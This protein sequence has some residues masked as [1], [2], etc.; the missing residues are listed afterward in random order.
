MRRQTGLAGHP[1]TPLTAQL[2]AC[3]GVLA[4]AFVLRMVALDGLALRGDEA[5]AV[6]GWT[7]PLAD[8]LGETAAVE[9]QPPLTFAVF[10]GWVTFAGDSE[11]A[12]RYLSV[13]S[14]VAGVAAVYAIGRRV[15]GVWGGALAALLMALNPFHVWHSQDARSYALWTALSALAVW[16]MLRA[17]ARGDRRDWAAYVVA[18][19]A[20]A[21]TFYLELAL[22]AFQNVYVLVTRR[23]D[24]ARLRRWF[25][26]QGMV[27]LILALWY[28]QPRLWANDYVGTAGGF[29]PAG[30]LTWVVPSLVFGQTLPPG[31]ADWVWVV[32][33]ALV[34]AG[35]VVAWR[36]DRAR[37]VF[38]AS[39][40]GAPL[41]LL[42]ALALVQ[43]IF[44]PRYILASSPA[45]MLMLAGLV[46]ALA[47]WRG[48]SA[49]RRAYLVGGL[50]SGLLLVMGLGLWHHY[51]NPMYRKS[52][53]WRGL[54]AFLEARVAPGDI[55]A[56]NTSDPAFGYYYHGAQTTV[57]T[58]PHPDPADT[59]AQLEALLSVHRAL[60]FLPTINPAWDADATALHWLEANAQLIDDLWSG[61]FRVQQWRAWAASPSELEDAA[62]TAIRVGDFASLVGYDVSPPMQRDRVLVRSGERLRL[63]LYWTPFARAPADYTAFVHLEGPLN[64]AT[65]TP[66]WAQDDHPPQHGRA[67][68]SQWHV[69]P[70]GTLL[71]DVY[72]L[73]LTGV[74]PDT[75]AL[76]VGMYNP[77]TG[78]RVALRDA[79]TD[80]AGDAV[81][82]FEVVVLPEP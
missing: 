14:G 76:R 44:R 81:A 64:P 67:P 38:L 59:A 29:D 41:V 6:L 45:Y 12:V 40:A 11:L 75:Y 65:G 80:Q 50:W 51:T 78:V 49:R 60:W 58:A 53:D 23:R 22:L 34:V 2:G 1:R 54:V 17:L 15:L 31:M 4:L 7:G 20:A 21:Y 69:W 57:P 39:Y 52:P 36:A 46:L 55:V 33:W 5:F 48:L 26:A 24:P 16:L 66:L 68:T 61:A 30:V 82:L 18:Q 42:S 56:Q 37:F 43:P 3:V 77:R 28:L 73:D 19:A 10:S 27:A 74:P 79:D 32:V 62:H 63:I 13:L 71:R 25:V 35:L 72:T 9:P 47:R 70:A 8:L